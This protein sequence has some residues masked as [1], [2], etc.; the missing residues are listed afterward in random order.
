MRLTGTLLEI[1][2][3]SGDFKGDSGDTVSYSGKRLHVL[4]GHEVVKV[5]VPKDLLYSHGYTA[6]QPVDL[7]VTVAANAGARG[8]YLS[9][10]LLGDYAP[11]PVAL[12]KAN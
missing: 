3:Y 9:C 5:K 8:A 12:A 7:R 6:G 4:D 10:Q 11:K 2:E 1:E